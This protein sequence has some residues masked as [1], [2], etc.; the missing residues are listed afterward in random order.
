MGDSCSKTY[1]K[2]PDVTK[3]DTIGAVRTIPGGCGPAGTAGNYL[4]KYVPN[5]GEYEWAGEGDGC[6]YCSASIP[7]EISCSS[8]CADVSCCAIVGK[9]G[10]YKRTS[11]KADPV[12]CCLKSADY[13]G[14][15]TCDPKYKNPTSE[16][17]YTA[18]KNYCLEGNRLF[19][20]DVCKSFCGNNPEE[21]FL[22][23][24]EKCNQPNG[25]F[26]P[27]C[28][29]WCMINHGMCDSSMGVYCEQKPEDPICSCIN[30]DLIKHKYNP[31]CEDRSCIDHGYHTS[32][33][34]SSF[35]DG[36]QIVDCSVYFDIEAEGNVE[37]DDV[38]I[39]QR[40]TAERESE[41]RL[42]LQEEQKKKKM[43]IFILITI[44]LCLTVIFL[45]LSYE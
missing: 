43:V 33:M 17:C 5:N 25:V 16:S 37:F 30:S 36:C 31:V 41:Q 34:I 2:M 22:Y 7:N 19:E 42:L 14:N 11:Y 45:S 21:C 28:H 44:T 12:I 10:T 3:T 4:K 13:V 18:I 15:H 32:S 6:H 20:E 9:R 1:P 39:D 40:C 26:N 8:G 27:Y 23:K 38:D 24:Q 35:G 29:N